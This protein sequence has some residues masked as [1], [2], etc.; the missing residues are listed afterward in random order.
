MVMRTG[1][2]NTYTHYTHTNA[3]H[4]MHYTNH[5]TTLWCRVETVQLKVYEDDYKHNIILSSSKD[6]K[7]KYWNTKT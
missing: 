1:T 3:T 4:N 2:E 7:M 5:Y 6:C